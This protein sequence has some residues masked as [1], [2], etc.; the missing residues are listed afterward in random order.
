MAVLFLRRHA[1]REANSAER[2]RF[3]FLVEDYSKGLGLKLKP[4]PRFKSPSLS[5]SGYPPGTVP[6]MCECIISRRLTTVCRG[7]TFQPVAVKSCCLALESPVGRLALFVG[8]RRGARL[9]VKM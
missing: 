4:Q 8:R 6:G 5:G 3:A 7:V 9:F 2:L 1:L